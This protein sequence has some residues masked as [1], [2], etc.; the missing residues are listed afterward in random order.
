MAKLTAHLV[1]VGK[2]GGQ[3]SRV[4]AVVALPPFPFA[5]ASSGPVRAMGGVEVA[6]IG[7]IPPGGT[8]EDADLLESGMVSNDPSGQ[9]IPTQTLEEYT[10]LGTASL[11]GN[12]NHLA[13][14][15]RRAGP[16]EVSGG[17]KLEGCLLYVDGDVK[18]QGGISESMIRSRGAG[19]RIRPA[20]RSP[21]SPSYS[22]P[23]NE[24]NRRD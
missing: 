24:S 6:G 21:R 14:R 20:P 23:P 9:A 8:I 13:G 1:G 12:A 4:Q 17:L 16:L 2:F 10:P 22:E 3:T 15:V 7:A 19:N 5:L 18:I 11:S